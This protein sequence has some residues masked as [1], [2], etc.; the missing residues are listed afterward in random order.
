MYIHIHIHRCVYTYIHTYKCI[1]IYAY[2]DVYVYIYT[3][4]NAPHPFPHIDSCN[5]Y[6]PRPYPCKSAKDRRRSGWD[7]R[8]GGVVPFHFM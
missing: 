8:G 3:Y 1:Y 5:V 2:I 6:I 7:G 4:I